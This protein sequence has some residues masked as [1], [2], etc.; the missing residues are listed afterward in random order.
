MQV[1][2]EEDRVSK[3]LGYF[4]VYFMALCGAV[5]LV[6]SYVCK[7]FM[8]LFRR[9]RGAPEVEAEDEA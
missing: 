6:V 9:L 1:L 2:P 5:V 7:A 4:L 8:R 3:A